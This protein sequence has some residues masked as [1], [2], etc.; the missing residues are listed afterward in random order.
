MNYMTNVKNIKKLSEQELGNLGGSS[1][2]DQYKDS[3]W[4]YIG[5]L[6]FDLTEGDII[7]IFSQYG[8]VVN[9]NLIREKDTGKSKGF[10]FLC[11]EDQRSTVLAVDNFNGIKVLNRTIRV[12]HVQNYKVPKS[13][14]KATEETKKLHAEGCAPK[15]EPIV[16][17][18]EIKPES[19]E[20]MLVRETLADQIEGEIKLPARLPI[21]ANVKT[22]KLYDGEEI[23]KKE[24]KKKKKKKSKKSKGSDSSDSEPDTKDKKKKKKEKRERSRSKEKEEKKPYKRDFSPSIPKR[25]RQ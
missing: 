12:D 10:C 7:C 6:P 18:K 21:Y 8:E 17:K 13:D 2:H 16:P 15:A 14:K 25:W 4:I 5:A 22:E 19:M 24:K 1:W 20:N 3:A 11:Y 9:I 23:E